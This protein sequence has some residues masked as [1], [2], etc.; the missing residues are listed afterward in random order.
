[1]LSGGV[2]ALRRFPALFLFGVTCVVWVGVVSWV[3][4]QVQSGSRFQPGR[5]LAMAPAMRS[6]CL[7]MCLWTCYERKGDFGAVQNKMWSTSISRTG[8]ATHSSSSSFNRTISNWE[9]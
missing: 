5:D 7:W 9:E 8:H 4:R 3:T 2:L 1:M 6:L